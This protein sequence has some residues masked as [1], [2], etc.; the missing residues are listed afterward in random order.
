MNT[1]PNTV[2]PTPANKDYYLV[3]LVRASDLVQEFQFDNQ[4]DAFAFAWAAE[5]ATRSYVK[6]VWSMRYTP[7]GYGHFYSAW[8]KRVAHVRQPADGTPPNPNGFCSRCRRSFGHN[9]GRY[10]LL[11]THMGARFCG[12]ACAEAEAAAHGYPVID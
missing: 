6:E 5:K 3:E 10:V 8:E 9:E 11:T 7:S 4:D 2:Q 1:E 12:R